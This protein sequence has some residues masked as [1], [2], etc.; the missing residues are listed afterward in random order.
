[1]ILGDRLG[2][3]AALT[4]THTVVL[5]LWVVGILPGVAAAAVVVAL[6]VPLLLSWGAYQADLAV[7]EGLGPRDRR[8]WTIAFY[9]L[10]PSMALYWLWWVRP[11]VR[12]D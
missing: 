5:V 2:R 12:I 7:N 3:Y 6:A 9:V 1:M 8:R 10:P 4:P 11:R